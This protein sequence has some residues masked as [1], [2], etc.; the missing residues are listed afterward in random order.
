MRNILMATLALTP[1]LLS[2]Q[3]QTPAQPRSDQ[4]AVL[5]SRLVAPAGIEAAATGAVINPVRISSLQEPKLIK[6]GPVVQDASEWGTSAGVS[7]HVTV[8]MT[9]DE[10]GVPSDLK[11]LD[12]GDPLLNQAVLDAV[13]RYRFSPAKLNATPIAVPMVLKVN[14]VT[15]QN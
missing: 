11:V 1:A 4:S 3:A 14:V 6:S 10:R 8:A 7:R 13:A 12:S 15:P 9:V 5:Q 2:V